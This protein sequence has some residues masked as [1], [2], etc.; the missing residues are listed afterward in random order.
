MIAGETDYAFGDVL[1]VSDFQIPL[2]SQQLL[3]KMQKH[4]QAGTCFYGLQIGC[5]PQQWKLYFIEFYS[6]G[7]MPPRK[8]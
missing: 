8:Y 6:E 7:Y 4:Q 3:A 5:S 2:P 1:W